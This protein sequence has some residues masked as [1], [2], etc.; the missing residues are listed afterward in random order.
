MSD[1]M[2]ANMSSQDCFLNSIHISSVNCKAVTWSAFNRKRVQRPRLFFN[3]TNIPKSKLT[4]RWYL[5]M[6]HWL[7]FR[8]I[9]NLKNIYFFKF[10]FFLYAFYSLILYVKLLFLKFLKI[11]K[12]IR[13]IGKKED[14][15]QLWIVTI[16]SMRAST[17][18]FNGKI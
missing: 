2:C 18:F 1:Y 8:K 3:D 9:V 14:W 16:I 6:C 5:T 7:I 11:F 15:Q 4:F 17:I 10:Y 12:N 13:I